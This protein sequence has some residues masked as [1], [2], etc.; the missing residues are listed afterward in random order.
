MNSIYLRRRLK[1]IVPEG[2]GETAIEVI[3]ALQRNIESLGFVLA[4]EVCQRLTTLSLPKIETFYKDLVSTLREMV[5]AHR[6]FNPFY[7]NFPA[8]VMELSRVELYW[9]AIIHYCTN[10]LIPFEKRERTPLLDESAPKVISLGSREEFERIFTLLVSAKT[11]LS[12]QDKKDVEWFVSQYREGIERLL[13]VD[14]AHKENL[15]VAGAALLKN[16]RFGGE[17][18]ATR[19][20]TPTDVL[21]LAAAFSE[22]DPSLAEPAK[23]AKFRRSERRR[24][25]SWV[26]RVPDPTEDMLRWKGRWIRLG[27]RLHPGEYAKE[28]PKTVVAFDVLRND[29]HFETFNSAV[30]R[31]LLAGDGAAAVALLRSRPGELA[32]RLDHLLRSAREPG[33][34]V[35]TF[36]RVAEQVSTP[37]LLQ[38]MTHFAHRQKR[39]GL[40][41]FFPKGDVARV[42]A[43]PDD[44]P[45]L[46]D[47]CGEAIVA[48]CEAT[49]LSRFAKLPSLGK[50]FLDPRLKDFP[51]PFSQRSAAK[52]LRTLVRGSRLPLTDGKVLRFFIW[53]K[54]GSARTDI[55]LSAGLFDENFRYVDVVSY[56]NLKALGGC[57]SGDIVDA[58]KGASEFIDLDIERTMA[59]G[60]RY[61]VMSINSFTMQPY[62]DLP[63]CFAGWMARQAAGSGEV[64]EPR[65]VQDKVDISSNTQVCLPA[66]FDLQAKRVVWADVAL[67]SHPYWNNLA[68][69]LSGVSLMLRSVLGLRKPSLHRLFELHIR[70]R[71]EAVATREAAESVF[72][73]DGGV[74]PFDLDRISA[75]FL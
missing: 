55:D 17:W 36:A 73:V 56:Y 9:N 49:L 44:L 39:D 25:L 40:R 58:P 18:L 48:S 8:Q 12:A 50:C 72:A 1:V 19:M 33:I 46:P 43:V 57:H 42:Q 38:A 70:A 22:G 3:A 71:G 63:E 35:S 66:I 47:G 26:E 51:V 53:W 4:P 31:H 75:E 61:V 20:K 24:L 41:V 28:F 21:R 23:F 65:T 16:T 29:R 32:R 14:I 11:S 37:V 13:P 7:P 15:A 27:E 64:F 68:N 30:E 52:A 59:G 74:T 6:A 54:N 69:N 62:C 67:R 5:G 60:A 10:K 45:V 2:D 34:V